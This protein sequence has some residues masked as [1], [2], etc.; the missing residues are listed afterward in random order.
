MGSGAGSVIEITESPS[1]NPNPVLSLAYDP[2]LHM[3]YAG[4]ADGVYT[5]TIASPLA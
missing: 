1:G 3:L 5:A 2:G 4:T